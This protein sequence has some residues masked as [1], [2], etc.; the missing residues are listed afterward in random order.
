MQS[1]ILHCL[2]QDC[3]VDH[4]AV[5][6]IFPG[7][8]LR[9]WNEI[10]IWWISLANANIWPA[11]TF[12]LLARAFEQDKCLL[13]SEV[14]RHIAQECIYGIKRSAP[15]DN[16]DQKLDHVQIL[17]DPLVWAGATLRNEPCYPDVLSRA[18]LARISE[19]KEANAS[20]PVHVLFMDRLEYDLHPNFL[21]PLSIA[22]INRDIYFNTLHPALK[23]HH[24][25]N[26]DK[27]S[28]TPKEYTEGPVNYEN[29]PTSDVTIESD[30][31]DDSAS[32]KAEE[33]VCETE[34]SLSAAAQ[35]FQDSASDMME[36]HRT[37][38]QKM[39]NLH[40]FLRGF[41]K[42]DAEAKVEQPR[43]SFDELRNRLILCEKLLA[44]NSSDE[45]QRLKLRV[46][47]LEQRPT[48]VNPLEQV[49]ADVIRKLADALDFSDLK[50]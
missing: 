28:V 2:N 38:T 16:P 18:L 44:C 15:F 10:C 17:I 33:K 12:Y 50:G 20:L 48:V 46:E 45:L 31:E 30:S 4:A 39:E 27:L 40:A 34:R 19:I 7:Q 14:L 43:E 23:D 49:Q 36:K 42:N 35:R 32:T 1:Q 41:T 13:T 21:V 26:L 22:F 24:Y 3:S 8:S 9:Q 29:A 11:C 5:K 25:A 37:K 47:K 6:K